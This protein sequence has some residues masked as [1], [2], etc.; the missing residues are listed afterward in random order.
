MKRKISVILLAAIFAVCMALGFGLFGAKPA[1]V[2]ATEYMEITSAHENGNLNSATKSQDSKSA[3]FGSSQGWGNNG[4]NY[5]SGAVKLGSANGNTIIN[6]TVTTTASAKIDFGIVTSYSDS[7][8]NYDAYS[9]GLLSISSCTVDEESASKISNQEA[10]YLELSNATKNVTITLSSSISVSDIYLVFRPYMYQGLQGDIVFSNFFFGSPVDP[11][12]YFT[13][14]GGAIRLD[15]HTG[16]RFTAELGT[17]FY[18]APQYNESEHAKT[19]SYGTLFFPT[20]LL[21]DYDIDDYKAYSGSADYISE[22]E[23][24]ASAYVAAVRNAGLDYI[25]E[26]VPVAIDANGKDIAKND[27]TTTVDHYILNG[28]IANVKY[29]NLAREFFG[30]AYKKVG[31]WNG[32]AYAYT[33]TYASFDDGFTRSVKTVATG[34]YNYYAQGSE[35]RG[36]LNKLLYK[37]AYRAA[38]PSETETA[39]ETAYGEDGA[40]FSASSIISV[41][42][43]KSST[44]IGIGGTDTVSATV[45]ICGKE[46][47]LSKG[48]GAVTFASANEAYATV[49]S[50]GVITGVAAGE[51]CVTVTYNG[52]EASCTVTVE[53]VVVPTYTLTVVGGTDS[54]GG[55]PYTEGTV[56][57]ITASETN[58]SG[59]IF[60]GWTSS[61]GGT[62]GN[63]A[64]RTTTFTMPGADVTITANYAP[65]SKNITVDSNDGAWELGSNFKR[66]VSND[67][68]SLAVTGISSGN[69]VNQCF[70]FKV[71]D[72]VGKTSMSFTITNN[73]ASGTIYLTFFISKEDSNQYPGDISVSPA[74]TSPGCV[75]GGDRNGVKIEV[76][77]GTPVTVNVTFS[78]I[79]SAAN[80]NSH[81]C[82]FR[83]AH[84]SGDKNMNGAFTIS[85][86]RFG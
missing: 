74:A 76:T 80:N 75:N 24:K 60:T 32:S 25:V 45:S 17:S 8:S 15:S 52:V 40:N 53:N 84:Q 81:N 65:A 73:N 69:S 12:D 49:S 72:M 44:T 2:E 1:T 82:N 13:M 57:N 21:D 23:T 83:F 37:I 79:P 33:Y 10:I 71:D 20:D 9:V 66:T 55:S 5:H 54:T 34:A 42:L 16:M 59:E 61:G 58:A 70:G 46:I 47:D 41:T 38:H 4:Q 27:T 77:V 26:A 86:V 36:I 62:F 6:F 67:N 29:A 64:N 63:A 78:A 85:N 56:V 31:T 28:S 68:K 39:A 3:T 18:E 43:N 35:Q 30:L 22:I 11:D 14:Q 48:S 50:A 7:A 19:V 51:T